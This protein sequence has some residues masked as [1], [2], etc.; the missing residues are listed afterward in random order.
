MENIL[1]IYMILGGVMLFSLFLVLLIIA[2]KD[3]LFSFYRR[4]SQRGADVFIINP[5]RNMSQY[6]KT[7][8]DG[9]FKIDGKM[10]VTNPHKLENLSPEMIKEVKNKLSL[11]YNKL[12][13][14]IEKREF[15]QQVI[16]KQLKGLEGSKENFQIIEALKLQF[17]ELDTQIN[18]LRAKLNDKEQS[19]FSRKRPAYF[20]IENDPVPK[21]FY[22]LYT[23]MDSVVLENII[24]RAQTKD[25]KS[26][27]QLEKDIA[28]IKKF[29][30]IA[31]ILGVLAGWFAFQ[32]NG[33]IK[34]LAD[35]SGVILSI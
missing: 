20:Y 28:F 24:S 7:P 6:F 23:E 1:F 26:M 22:E 5:S 4:F 19:Y 27:A 13:K 33:A 16:T 14:L 8:K 32:N 15:K 11:K 12:K 35:A 29:V 3:I 9:V 31:V 25:P 21:D 30:L 2:G 34:Q 17:Q 18:T 10:Y